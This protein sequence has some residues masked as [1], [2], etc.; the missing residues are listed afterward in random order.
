[1]LTF[2]INPKVGS[3]IYIFF[4]YG[5][6]LFSFSSILWKA[7]VW[8]CRRVAVYLIRIFFC[9]LLLFSWMFFLYKLILES[10][11]Y[12][13]SGI[14]HNIVKR[15]VYDII[16]VYI[17]LCTIQIRIVCES[18]N[19]ENIFQINWNILQTADLISYT[20]ALMLYCNL[21]LWKQLNIFE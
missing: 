4:S 2:H 15:V 19:Y 12:L 17:L 7:T 20:P 9:A 8:W 11:M 21:G 1:M 14:L 18:C 5:S 3:N 16:A 6:N 13:F 10:Q